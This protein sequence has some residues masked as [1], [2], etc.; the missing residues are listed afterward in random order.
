MDAAHPGTFVLSLDE[1]L[2]IARHVNRASFGAILGE[3]A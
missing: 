1:G 3:K 2:E